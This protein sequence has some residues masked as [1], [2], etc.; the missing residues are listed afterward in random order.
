M[1]DVHVAMPKE[2]RAPV[3]AAVEQAVLDEL[4]RLGRRFNDVRA[5]LS[6]D[7][8]SVHVN[9]GWIRAEE[10]EGRGYL[11]LPSVEAAA[12]RAL[13]AFTR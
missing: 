13:V 8:H 11:R 6:E 9:I 10:D 1:I 12:E 7:G 4:V 5:T 2:S 3:L